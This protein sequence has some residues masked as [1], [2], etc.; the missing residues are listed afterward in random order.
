MSLEMLSARKVVE[1]VL[2]VRAE[3]RKWGE[4]GVVWCGVERSAGYVR[5]HVPIILVVIEDLLG[6]CFIYPPSH[7]IGGYVFTWVQQILNQLERHLT[8]V[9]NIRRRANGMEW[10]FCSIVNMWRYKLHP[11]IHAN[12]EST[13]MWHCWKMCMKD[14]ICWYIRCPRLFPNTAQWFSFFVLTPIRWILVTWHMVRSKL[15]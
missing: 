3:V 11:V 10:Y 4:G 6:R 8:T 13:T 5:V 14:V 1:D 9:R 2:C 12:P 7:A 15:L